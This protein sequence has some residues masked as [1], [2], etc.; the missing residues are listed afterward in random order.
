MQGAAAASLYVDVPI[1]GASVGFGF[2]AALPWLHKADSR[3]SAS[4]LLRPL[5]WCGRM[6]Y[7]LYLVHQLPVKAVSTA[8][9]RNGTTGAVSTLLLTVPLS[10]GVAL[11]LGWAFHLLVERRFLNSPMRLPEAAPAS[12]R[13]LAGALA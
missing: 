1:F 7:S 5:F 10:V 3:I 13:S 9:Y 12:P 4:V 8:L 6:C 2:A 11:A